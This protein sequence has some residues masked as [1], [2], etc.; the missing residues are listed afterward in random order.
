MWASVSFVFAFV[1]TYSQ[2]ASLHDPSAPGA[3]FA[4]W[5][6]NWAWVPI[7]VLLLTYPLLL[8][9][10]GKLPSP[11]WRPV[12]WAVAILTVAWS[13]AFAFEQND[14]TNGLDQPA[15]NPYMSQRFAPV[16]DAARIWISFFVIAAFGACVAALVVRYRRSRGVER[17][18]IRWLMFA[19]VLTVAWFMLPLDHGNGGVA[20]FIQGFVLMLIPISIGI[21]ILQYRLYDIDVVIRKTLV[22]G[23]LAVFIGAVYVA[24]VVGLGSFADSTGLTDRRHRARRRRVP[25]GA[26]PR[27]PLGE[28]ARLRGARDAVRGPR[29][30]SGIASARPTRATTSCPGSPA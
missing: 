1:G 30:G 3:V 26:R 29:R 10:D 13:M 5:L 16:F 22:V 11:R 28:P 6:G 15:T 7:F 4:N 27:E 23:V 18:Q 8:F 17:E 20:D 25:A 12:G 9:P 14:Y 2:W 24:V 19:G 21:A